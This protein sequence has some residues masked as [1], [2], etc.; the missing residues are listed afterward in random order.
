MKQSIR[1]II[2]PVVIVVLLLAVLFGYGIAVIDMPMPVW[3]KVIFGIV[4][5]SLSGVGIYVLVQRIQEIR[6]GEEDD[7]SHY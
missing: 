2:A 3:I 6:S 4:L 1:K 7:L 5:V